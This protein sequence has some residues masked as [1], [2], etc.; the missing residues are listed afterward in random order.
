MQIAELK[1]VAALRAVVGFLGE[2]DQFDWW[3][4]SFFA[5][6][7]KAF[8]APVFPRT[9][10]L[11][12]C[13]GVTRAAALKHDDRIGVGDVFHLFRLPEDIEQTLHRMFQD[14]PAGESMLAGI[15]N[16]DA[17]VGHLRQFAQANASGGVGPVRVGGT[18][19]LRAARTWKVAAA[20][21]SQAFDHGTQSFPFFADRP[22][23]RTLIR[24]DCRPETAWWRRLAC[25]W[26][27]GTRA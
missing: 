16:R 4:S 27:C 17:A 12:Q 15:A 7:S 26:S 19:D 14:A 6:G 24:L 22:C 13:E 20:C 8:L 5:A 1:A 11:A 18:L 25:C 3:P 10:W 21:Y 23:E 9:Q 2:K